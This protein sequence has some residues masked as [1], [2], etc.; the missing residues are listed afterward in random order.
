MDFGFNNAIPPK[1]FD[2]SSIPL[3]SVWQETG[4]KQGNKKKIQKPCFGMQNKNPWLKRDQPPKI[5]QEQ[6]RP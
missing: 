2:I 4:K 5:V 6:P 3:P 1:T